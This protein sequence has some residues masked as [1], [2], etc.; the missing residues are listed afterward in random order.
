MKK[1]LSMRIY[2][3]YSPHCSELESQQMKRISEIIAKAIIQT[4]FVEEDDIDITENGF[5]IKTSKEQYVQEHLLNC[6]IDDLEEISK[7]YIDEKL[8]AKA[9]E[10]LEEI[11]DIKRYIEITKRINLI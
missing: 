1:R 2:D 11:E 5:L 6:H 4:T 7:S 8:Y 10:R 9:I 3:L